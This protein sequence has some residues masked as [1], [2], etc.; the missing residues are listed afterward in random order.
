MKPIICILIF[1]ASL[2][3]YAQADIQPSDSYQAVGS[4][5]STTIV[6]PSVTVAAGDYWV[7]FVHSR[8]ASGTAAVPTVSGLNVTWQQVATVTYDNATGGVRRITAWVGIVSAG[9]TGTVTATWAVSNHQRYIQVFKV[10]GAATTNNGLDGV[11]QAVTGSGNS[12]TPTITMAAR[13][14]NSSAYAFYGMTQSSGTATVDGPYS[15][16]ATGYGPITAFGQPIT[17][18]FPLQNGGT[19]NTPSLT[20]SSAYDWGGIALEF[21]QPLASRRIISIN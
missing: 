9:T 4:S 2:S 5:G 12:A 6:S 8:I 20:L 11:V 19:D 21:G 17:L 1:F 3:A 10:T 13:Q 18:L 16:L 7:T 14:S 15:T